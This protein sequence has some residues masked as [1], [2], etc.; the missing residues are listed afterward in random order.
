[1]NSDLESKTV[2]RLDAM[3]DEEWVAFMAYFARRMLEEQNLLI[4]LICRRAQQKSE[5]FNERSTHAKHLPSDE[6]ASLMTSCGLKLEVL[7]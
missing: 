4:E 2:Q 3:N 5:A 7:G 1:M 6:I